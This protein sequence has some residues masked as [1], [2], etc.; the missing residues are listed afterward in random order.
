MRK[1][2]MIVVDSDPRQGPR[3]AEALRVAAGLAAWMTNE[4]TLCLMGPA[5]MLLHGNGD[6]IGDE[7]IRMAWSVLREARAAVFVDAVPPANGPAPGTVRQIT[8]PA[9]AR[10]AAQADYLLRF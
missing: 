7:D 10:L 3:A 8:P 9:F 4:I 5:A 6:L 1:K 2:V